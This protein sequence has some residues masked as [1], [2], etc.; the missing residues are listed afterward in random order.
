MV[1]LTPEMLERATRALMAR[2]AEERLRN[3]YGR[4]AP[5][6]A[7]EH[8]RAVLEAALDLRWSA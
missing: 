5:A 8:A 7:R 4:V 6:T 1:D 2:E 3:I